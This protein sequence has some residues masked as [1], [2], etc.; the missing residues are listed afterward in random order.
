MLRNPQLPAI[1]YHM[2][3][4]TGWYSNPKQAKNTYQGP[5]MLTFYLKELESYPNPQSR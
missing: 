4:L 3:A 5:Q 1:N 2:Q